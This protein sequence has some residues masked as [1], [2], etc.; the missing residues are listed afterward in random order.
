MA[1]TPLKEWQ[2]ITRSMAASLREARVFTVEGLAALPD[3]KLRVVGPDGRTWREKARAYLEISRSGGISTAMVSEM[4][5]MRTELADR[6]RQIAELD[7]RITALSKQAANTKPKAAVE[8]S[9]A[10]I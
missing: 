4:E 7:E 3:E 10:I 2:E 1:G 9:P 5:R 6:D 8:P